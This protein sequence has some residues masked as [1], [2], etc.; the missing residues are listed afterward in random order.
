MLGEVICIKPQ[1]SV[2]HPPFL[3]IFSEVMQVE[4]K[5]HI[6][7]RT[8]SLATS[9]NSFKQARY[10]LTVYAGTTVHIKDGLLA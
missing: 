8:F 9:L 4:L 6:L 7:S 2:P 1:I 10:S 5:P 3:K